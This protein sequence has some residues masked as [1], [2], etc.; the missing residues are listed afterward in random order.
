MGEAVSKILSSRSYEEVV[1]NDLELIWLIKRYC[2]A[3][4]WIERAMSRIVS[5]HP[6]QDICL[7]LWIAF[8]LGWIEVGHAH[9][10]V[11]IINVTVVLR[12]FPRSAAHSSD[13]KSPISCRSVARRL[14]EAK[15]PV[16]YDRR[17]RPRTEVNPESY[18]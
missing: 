12:K 14:F 2:K 15:R 13:N 16:E 17:L 10:W 7:V 4:P 3:R 6:M 1:E 9:F 11:C 18:G 8:I 5:K